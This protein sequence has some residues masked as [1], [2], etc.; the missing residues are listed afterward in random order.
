MG[1]RGL[2]CRRPL[3]S[4]QSV[5]VCPL[6]LR[7]LSTWFNETVSEAFSLGAAVYRMIPCSQG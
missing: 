3:I 2:P 5:E 4:L 7:A 6:E 1:H